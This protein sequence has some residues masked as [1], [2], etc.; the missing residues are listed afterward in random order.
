MRPRTVIALILIG[1]LLS[2]FAVSLAT[3]VLV[4]SEVI[5]AQK[6]TP[7]TVESV[8]ESFLKGGDCSL[9][10]L[11]ELNKSTRE[12]GRKLDRIAEELEELN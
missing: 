6:F 8:P 4:D 12:N 11:M 5:A 3:N 9:Q 2:Q 7:E 10:V 1:A